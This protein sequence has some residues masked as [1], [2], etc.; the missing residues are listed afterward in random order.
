M[1]SIPACAGEPPSPASIM[2]SVTVYPRVCGGTI[3]RLV[4]SG[5]P[6]GLSPRVRG[7]PVAGIEDDSRVWSIPACA[8]EP[9]SAMRM[10]SPSSVYPRVCGGTH[11]G[12]PVG[13]RSAGLSPRVRGN[14]RTAAAVST[15]LGSIPACAGEPV[16]RRGRKVKT[17]VYPRVCGG[18]RPSVRFTA[19][20]RGLSPRVRGNPNKAGSN[21][22]AGRSI[23]ACA[24]EPRPRPVRRRAFTVYPRVCGGTQWSFDILRASGGLSPRVRGNQ[25]QAQPEQ[26]HLGSIPACA[27][28]PSL[29]RQPG[30]EQRV[31]PRVCGGTGKGAALYLTRKGLSP[32]VRGNPFAHE[33]VV[34]SAR[35]IPACAG[36]PARSRWCDR[37]S[38]VYPRVCGGTAASASVTC[39]SSGLSPRVRGNPGYPGIVAGE[40]G[41]IPACAGEPYGRRL[42]LCCCRVYPRVCG[43]TFGFRRL[44]LALQGLSPRVRGNPDPPP[45]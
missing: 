38:R 7:N 34:G 18:T 43:G 19:S 26:R 45:T 15:Q 29:R 14:P 4:G 16:G 3:T 20:I 2:A 11:R 36:E 22:A 33:S 21:S 13:K 10:A 28:E 23:P 41:S 6:A 17:E 37:R 44:N 32:R 12:V 5:L 24:G 9:T 40:L 42:F 31:Y 39:R 25:S 8:G 35:S 1:R 30:T 27:G